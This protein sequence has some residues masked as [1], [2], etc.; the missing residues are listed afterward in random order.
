M[1][2]ELTAKD[3]QRDIEGFQNRIQAAREKLAE[4]SAGYLPYQKHKKREKQRRDLQAEIEH[5][6]KLR[7]YAR[8][9]LN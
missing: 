1:Q 2:I 8:E 7:G 5:V 3:I 9:A 6:Q 4:L